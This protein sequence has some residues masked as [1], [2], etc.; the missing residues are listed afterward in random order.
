MCAVVAVLISNSDI[1]ETYL[2]YLRAGTPRSKSL[3]RQLWRLS[4]DYVRVVRLRNI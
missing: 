4:S 3:T 2:H 1:A